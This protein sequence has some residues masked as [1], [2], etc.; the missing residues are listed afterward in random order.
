MCLGSIKS[1][2]FFISRI[3]LKMME[4]AY[5]NIIQKPGRIWECDSGRAFA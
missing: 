4:N 1:I 5:G 2:F 3:Q